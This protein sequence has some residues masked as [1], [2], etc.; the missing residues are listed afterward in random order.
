M[1]LVLHLFTDRSL[2]VLVLV[3][4]H[5]VVLGWT[6]GLEA[7]QGQHVGQARVHLCPATPLSVGV[8]CCWCSTVL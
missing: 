1:Q 2:L 8:V 3:L 5:P 4:L 6:L 7:R